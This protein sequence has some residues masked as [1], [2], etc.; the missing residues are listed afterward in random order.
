MAVAS[1]LVVIPF[2]KCDATIVGCDG[3]V[4]TGLPAERLPLDCVA[5]GCV[6]ELCG[7]DVVTGLDVLACEFELVCN[8]EWCRL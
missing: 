1:M 7:L 4:G 3:C 6:V 5:I 8:N 2:A